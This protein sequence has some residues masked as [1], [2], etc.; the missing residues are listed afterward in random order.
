MPVTVWHIAKKP[1]H[2][3]IGAVCSFI[4][5]DGRCQAEKHANNRDD[6]HQ[7]TDKAPGWHGWRGRS[8]YSALAKLVQVELKEL[9]NENT[10]DQGGPDCAVETSICGYKNV[11]VHVPTKNSKVVKYTFWAIS[12]SDAADMNSEKGCEMFT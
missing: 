2:V 8:A 6:N 10:Y 4:D 3:H 1:Y 5:E 9:G 7:S 12:W 11:D